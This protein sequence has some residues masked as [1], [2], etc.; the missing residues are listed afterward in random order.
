M[1]EKVLF[2]ESRGISPLTTLLDADRIQRIPA[3]CGVTGDCGIA[4]CCPDCLKRAGDVWIGTYSD[5]LNSR[6][7]QVLGS[8]K[9]RTLQHTG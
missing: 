7:F 6:R 4:W 1:G 8:L 2:K 3:K 9:L 5:N